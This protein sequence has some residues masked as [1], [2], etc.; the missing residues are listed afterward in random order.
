VQKEIGR[1]WQEK[2]ITVVQEHY[3]T[4]ATDMLLVSYRRK[5]LG[6][7]RNVSALAICADGEEHCLGIKMFSD[8]L[9]SDGWRTSYIGPKSPNADVLDY[10]RKNRTDLIAIS[11]TTPLHLS[12]AKRLIADIKALPGRQKPAVL[13]GGAVLNSQPDLWQRMGADG[14]AA[15]VLEGLDAANRLLDER[16]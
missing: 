4:A 2:R 5:F 10:L 15:T 11:I 8:M 3:C 6:N 9:Q 1:L 12:S 13:V 7:G 14:W 16:N